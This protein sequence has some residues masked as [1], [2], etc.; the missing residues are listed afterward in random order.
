MKALR[1]RAEDPQ[2]GNSAFFI[3]DVDG[4]GRCESLEKMIARYVMGTFSFQD[5][6]CKWKVWRNNPVSWRNK[7]EGI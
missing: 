3:T 1:K 4:R 2:N 7:W 5:Q 6:V